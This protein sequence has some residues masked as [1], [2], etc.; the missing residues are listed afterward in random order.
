MAGGFDE[1]GLIHAL[2]HAIAN[3]FRN[4][5]GPR[6]RMVVGTDPGRRCFRLV[7]AR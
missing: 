6:S 3:S 2:D 4:C 5:V 1:F 7:V